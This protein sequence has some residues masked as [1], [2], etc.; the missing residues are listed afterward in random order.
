MMNELNINYKLSLNILTGLMN[1]NLI[2]REEFDAI[3]RENQ[4]SFKVP[5]NQYFNLISSPS[6][7]IM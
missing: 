1:K 4:K 2:T 3:D 6:N 5:E 7:Y